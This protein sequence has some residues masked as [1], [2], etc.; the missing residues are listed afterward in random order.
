M[1][2]PIDKITVLNRGKKGSK[3][4][5]K[6]NVSNFCTTPENAVRN[7]DPTTSIKEHVATEL[8]LVYDS[9]QIETLVSDER[10]KHSPFPSLTPTSPDYETLKCSHGEVDFG[11]GNC[12]EFHNSLPRIVDL[13][14]EDKK[15]I[16]QLINELANCKE[17]KEIM[18]REL[19]NLKELVQQQM[20]EM[21]IT[22][23]KFATQKEALALE[24]ENLVTSRDNLSADLENLQNCVEIQKNEIEKQATCIA[25]L[26]AEKKH[27]QKQVTEQENKLKVAVSNVDT[28]TEKLLFYEPRNKM[29]MD[30]AR[31]AS[32]KNKDIQ[33]SSKFSIHQGEKPRLVHSNDTKV[34]GCSGDA[35]THV[36]QDSM[37]C[38]ANTDVGFFAVRMC[39]DL[40]SGAALVVCRPTEQQMAHR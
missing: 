39:P 31:P 20:N 23:E 10:S 29:K 4:V 34:E 9:N 21:A 28:L 19:S 26:K 16:L 36:L 8:P 2:R 3:H 14:L 22:N 38:S 40:G 30:N 35:G 33:M 11:G 15:R 18:T 7:P 1:S 24:V 13:C 17:E 5:Q 6:C 12:G 27:L 37:S 32:P 25:A